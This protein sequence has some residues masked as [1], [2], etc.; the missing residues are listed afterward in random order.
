MFDLAVRDP[1]CP[2]ME[3]SLSSQGVNLAG[4]L[5][6]LLGR[7]PEAMVQLQS[8]IDE[9]FRTMKFLLLQVLVTLIL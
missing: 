1:G 5:V 3:V 7:L 2:I 6:S 8:E 4:S 9:N